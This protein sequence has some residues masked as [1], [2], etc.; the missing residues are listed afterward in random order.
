MAG[1]WLHLRP[2]QRWNG[3]GLSSQIAS[4]SPRSKSIRASLFPTE[5]RASVVAS[6]F[7]GTN[8]LKV[9]LLNSVSSKIIL[10]L[11][12]AKLLNFIKKDRYMQLSLTNLVISGVN[13]QRR[14]LS[15]IGTFVS[16]QESACL[17]LFNKIEAGQQTTEP[18]STSQNQNGGSAVDTAAQTPQ[19][20]TPDA[21]EYVG[22]ETILIQ[23]EVDLQSKLPEATAGKAGE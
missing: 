14:K 8:L 1:E 23:E 20:M 18:P 5:L 22:T 6:D 7:L 16:F 9:Y 17:F 2:H 13:F 19:P 3:P 12:F 4:L 21:A 10:S 15:I 11:Y